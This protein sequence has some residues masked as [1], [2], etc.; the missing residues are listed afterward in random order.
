MSPDHITRMRGVETEVD[1]GR[2]W[3]ATD[4]PG[5]AWHLWWMPGSGDIIGLRTSEPYQEYIQM[6][7]T[8]KKFLL[9]FLCYSRK[10][11]DF[12]S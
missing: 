4:D 6:P 11:S 1:L 3:R 5:A 10:F 7:S 12:L 2:G 9:R 8:I